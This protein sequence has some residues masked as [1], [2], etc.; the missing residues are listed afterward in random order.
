MNEHVAS[1]N[2]LYD[3]TLEVRQKIPG[4]DGEFEKPI[5]LKLKI[6]S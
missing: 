3:F 4:I 5:R 6:V 2:D 1:I